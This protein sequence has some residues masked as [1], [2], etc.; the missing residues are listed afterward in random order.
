MTEPEYKRRF[1]QPEFRGYFRWTR[2]LTDQL[3]IALYHACH[4]AELRTILEHGELGLRSKWALGLPS[5]GD[6][7][8]PGAWVG[9]NY[10]HDGN[11]YGPFVLEFPLDVLNGRHFM[12]FKRKGRDNRI[13]YFFVQYEARIPI[14]RFEKQIW[15]NVKPSAYFREINAKE[16]AMRPGVIYD[17]VVTQPI[18]LEGVTISAVSHPWCVSK[19]CNGMTLKSS[20]NHLSKIAEDAFYLWL[21]ESNEY[22]ELFKRFAVLEGTQVELIDPNDRD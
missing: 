5:Y 9:L 22:K 4:E 1:E 7:S 10:F 14:Y 20:R 18:D 2:K 19:A 8:A 17:I 21:S 3:G 6:W 13:R 11:Y 15:R 12:A 16:L